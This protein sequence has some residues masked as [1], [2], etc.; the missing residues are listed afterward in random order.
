MREGK[1]SKRRVIP[2]TAKVATDL[3]SYYINHRHAI[4]AI[5]A[6]GEK[7]FMLNSLN[8]RM[9]GC[10][11]HSIF[12]KMMAK[13]VYPLP[14]TDI[15]LHHLRHSIATHLLR[16]SMGMLFIKDFLGHSSLDATQIYAKAQIGQLKSI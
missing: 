2:L 14:S 12:K 8:S 15:S 5:N 4:Q 10:T 1:G 13:A 3:E 16:G 7:A 6:D 9:K 11:Y